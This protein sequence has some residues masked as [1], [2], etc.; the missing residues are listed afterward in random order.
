MNKFY[1]HIYLLLILTSSS[2]VAQSYNPLWIPDTLT[3]NTFNLTVR[4]TFRQ[5]LPGQQ[6]IVGAV[7]GSWW[8]PTLIWNK[9]DSIQINLQN[10]LMDSTTMHWHGIHLPAVADGGPHQPIA[11]GNSWS[12]SFEV[13]NS[14]STYWYH[15]HLHMMTEEQ[16][17]MG[18]GGLIIVRDTI[19]SQL[20]LP[21]TYGV[22]DIPVILSDRRFD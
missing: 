15:P 18:I 17:N 2:A 11:P 9:G 20:L 4:D 7:N 21:R 10:D 19:E 14:A 22:D 1:Y 8:G 3:G 6:T 12:P 5:F 13:M 16:V